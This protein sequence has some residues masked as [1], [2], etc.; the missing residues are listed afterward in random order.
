MSRDPSKYVLSAFALN[1]STTYVVSLTVQIALKSAT[2]SVDIVVQQSNIVAVIAGGGLQS[3]RLFSTFSL[4][5]SGS[6]DNDQIGDARNVGLIYLWSC[7]QTA[8]LHSSKCSFSFTTKG[9][10]EYELVLIANKQTLGTTSTFSVLVSDTSRSA[11]ASVSVTIIPATNPAVE[12]L[13]SIASDSKMDVSAKLV[14]TSAVTL[15]GPGKVLWTVSDPTLDLAAIC[16]TPIA[17]SYS[18]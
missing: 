12:I 2:A 11:T 9:L 1:S 7:F 17:S 16:A 18:A 8:P 13:T 15:P 4:D 10:Q 6:Y 14:L 3:I 5:A